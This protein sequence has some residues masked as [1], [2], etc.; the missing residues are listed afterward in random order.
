MMSQTNHTGAS[1]RR[2]I[3]SALLAVSFLVPASASAITPQAQ[4]GGSNVRVRCADCPSS[5]EADRESRILREKLLLRLDSLRYAFE[6]Q[7]LDDADRDR[8]RREMVLAFVA[9]ERSLGEEQMRT[10]AMRTS[11]DSMVAQFRRAPEVA[12][13]FETRMNHGYLGVSFDGPNTEYVRDDERIIRFYQYPRIA[14]VEPSS[15]ADRAGIRVGDTLL[16]MNGIDV[17]ANEISL[18]KLLVPNERVSIGLRRDGHARELRVLVGKSPEYFVRRSVPSVAVAP[19]P[20]RVYV[21]TPQSRRAPEAVATPQATGQVWV[22]NQGV[23]GARVETVT[24]GLGKALGVESGVLVVR[25]GSETPA[26]ESG[27][28]DGDVIVRADGKR[29]AS[30]RDLIAILQDM[31]SHEG[32]KLLVIRERRQREVTLRY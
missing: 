14:L 13:A 10:N 8:V 25:A 6:N 19:A 23:A 17:S 21:S 31:S 30:V 18:T 15:P 29:V 4:A 28:R 2:H 11:R 16:T 22:F 9:L 1:T 12:I 27:I 20:S 3:L 5:R 32:V 7:R 24:E 26:F